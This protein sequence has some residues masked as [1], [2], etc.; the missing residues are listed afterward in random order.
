MKNMSKQNHAN[1]LNIFVA[2]ALV[3][4]FIP[5]VPR[6]E[7]QA[8][9]AEEEEKTLELVDGTYDESQV[10]VKF[11]DS[12]DTDSSAVLESTDSVK[13]EG[14]AGVGKIDDDIATVKVE[15]GRSVAEAIE[16]L[17]SDPRVEY[18]EPDYI[19]TLA[20]DVQETAEEI[21][22]L[23]KTSV[24]DP[25]VNSQWHITDSNAKV[26]E[27]WD[28]AKCEG[29]ITIA[30]IDSGIDTDHPD[31][32]GN[33]IAS[34][35]SVDGK[36]SVEDEYGHGTVVAG[37]LSAQTN[38]KTGVSGVS[39]NANLIPIKAFKG[40][41]TSTGYIM[42]GLKWVIDNKDAYN[43]KVINMSFGIELNEETSSTQA[44]RSYINKA[45]DAGILV[46]CAS[47]NTGQ[48]SS[49]MFPATMS[50]TL[51]VGAIDSSHTVA[52][53][54]LGGSALDVVAPGSSIYSTI[55]PGTSMYQNVKD[56]YGNA[57][58]G[59]SWACPFVS[60]TAALCY[61]VNDGATAEQVKSWITSTAK[62]LGATGKDDDYGYGQVVVCDAVSKAKS[63]A[64]YEVLYRDYNPY[65]GEHLFTKSWKEYYNL[66]TIGWK[67]EGVAWKS[68]VV[69]NSSVYRLYNPYSGDHHY[70]MS[71]SEYDDLE[72]RGWKKE[73]SVWYSASSSNSPVYRLY[74]PYA[75]AGSHHYTLSEKEYQDLKKAGW[76]QEG[77]GWFA[78]S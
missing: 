46:V 56:K 48:A 68:P 52:Y 5:I 7:A 14:E 55:S 2:F 47:G 60:A 50:N 4:A 12:V 24:N 42:S 22:E 25:L 75:T 40:K 19:A 44:I 15:D 20:D 32:S 36:S 53:Y 66:S 76:N 74:N 11:K 43:I 16:E 62:D 13:D 78:L 45:Y 57:G 30:Y 72:T 34:Y 27:A 37:I 35:N 9:Q 61:A 51:A 17:E 10:I 71:K 6:V 33:V 73:G 31:L 26:Q 77:I 1:I 41:E 58:N 23:Q 28:V 18:A 29:N 64:T 63:N 70:T 69:M 54:S 8:Q 39:Y 67:K 49:M 21:A 59:T 38:N 3:L 65:S